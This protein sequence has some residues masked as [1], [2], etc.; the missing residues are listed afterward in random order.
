VYGKEFLKL[1][2]LKRL[3][4]LIT[5]SDTWHN[6]NVLFKY[7]VIV[8]LAHV[9]ISL[10]LQQDQFFLIMTHV[11]HNPYHDKLFVATLCLRIC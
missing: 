10:L 1:Y 3:D 11:Q 2:K 9:K 4:G 7:V 5:S 6:L 8:D